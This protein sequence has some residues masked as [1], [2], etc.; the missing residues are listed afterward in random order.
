MI[1][2]I[3]AK[4][5][6]LLPKSGGRYRVTRF[7]LLHTISKTKKNKYRKNKKTKRNNSRSRLRKYKNRNISK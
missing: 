6:N 3:E 4:V 5:V 7:K 1:K 2:R